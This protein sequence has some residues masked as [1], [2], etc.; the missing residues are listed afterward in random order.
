MSDPEFVSQDTI[1]L[2]AAAQ[3]GDRDATESL[4]ERYYPRVR[5]VVALRMGMTLR[6]WEELDDIAQESMLDA[7]RG[8]E[9]FEP[10]S[11]G[12]FRNWISRIVENNIRDHARK[13]KAAKRGSGKV[14]NFAAYGANVLTDSVTPGMDP[15]PSEIVAGREAEQRLEA[16]L[17]GLDERHREVITLRRLCE[18]SYAEVAAE[19]GL[20]KESTA[21]S[22]FSRA[23]SRLSVAL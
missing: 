2:V 7:F 12:S 10:E 20:D 22:L 16:A 15:T 19:M 9:G 14:R 8:L 23:L 3:A 11:E 13:G 17:L 21:R 1:R 18:M 4:F 5:Q 6:Q